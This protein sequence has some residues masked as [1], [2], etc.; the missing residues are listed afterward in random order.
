MSAEDAKKI[1]YNDMSSEEANLWASKLSHQSIRVYT[2]TTSYAAWRHI[3][4]TY[5]VGTEDKTTFT[6]EM[7]SSIIDNA[8]KL[9]PTAFDVVERCDG[10]HCLMISRPEWLASVLRRTAGE[11]F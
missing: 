3:P 2:S 11:R 5:V 8:K 1:F 6:P 9:E 4:S 7:V 10:G